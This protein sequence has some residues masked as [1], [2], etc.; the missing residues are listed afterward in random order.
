MKRVKSEKQYNKYAIG[1]IVYLITDKDQSERIVIG[2]LFRGK[3]HYNYD[4][5]C[6]A[7]SCWHYEYEISETKIIR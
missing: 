7:T 4:L 1:D 2:I 6:G 5:A 3:G